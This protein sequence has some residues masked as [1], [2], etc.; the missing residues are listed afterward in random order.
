MGCFPSSLKAQQDGYDK[1]SDTSSA[2]SGGSADSIIGQLN[3]SHREEPTSQDQSL[4]SPHEGPSS[5]RTVLAE[6][7]WARWHAFE[8]PDLANCIHSFGA[9]YAE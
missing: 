4:F 6:R 8:C 9:I 3:F 1:L 2:Y 7:L 5:P